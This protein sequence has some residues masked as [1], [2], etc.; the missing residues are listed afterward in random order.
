MGGWGGQVVGVG[1]GGGSRWGAVVHE[2]DFRLQTK[3]ILLFV[4][5]RSV[6]ANPVTTL[7]HTHTTRTHTQ[8]YITHAVHLDL[9]KNT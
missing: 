9:V 1:V 3:W 7:T 4:P 2:C 5:I 6:F 8:C